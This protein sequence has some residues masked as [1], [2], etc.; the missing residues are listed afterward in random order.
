MSENALDENPGNEALYEAAVEALEKLFSDTSVSVKKAL[1][2]MRSMID[3]CK[4]RIECLEMD[5]ER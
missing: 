2:N 4:T 3:E 5:L 1:D